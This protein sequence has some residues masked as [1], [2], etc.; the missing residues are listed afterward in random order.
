MYLELC[1]NCP[2]KTKAVGLLCKQT[3]PITSNPAPSSANSCI[4][5]SSLIKIEMKSFLTFKTPTCYWCV[6]IINTIL[7]E[8]ISCPKLGTHIP[9]VKKS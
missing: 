7:T 6:N 1:L 8:I 2:V 5:C 9:G 3:R 4:V